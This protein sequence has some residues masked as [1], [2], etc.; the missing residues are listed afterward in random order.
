MKRFWTGVLAAGVALVMGAGVAAADDLAK[1]KDDGVMKIAMS[2]AYPPFNFVNDR[3]EVVGFDA[4]IG[5]EIAKRIGVEGRIVTTAWDGI[6]A[7]LLAKKYDTIVGSMTIT[8]E[9]EKVVDFV[10]PYYHAGRAV[11][12]TET[13][14]VKSLADLKGKT[15]GVTLGET[16]E[17]WA[18]AQDGWS[19]RTY[20]G[21]PE[22]LLELKAGRVQAIVND[23]IP[24]RVAIKEN[25]EKLRQLD[26]PDIEGGAVAIGIAIRKNNP[27][28]HAAMQ[29]ALDEMMADGTYEKIS[30]EWVGADIR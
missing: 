16:H 3:N 10:G 19:V 8:P 27:D 24:V 26:T 6:L 17:K 4:A 11:F 23:N 1:I 15:V 22:L 29:T 12:V 28:L 30:M 2:G 21:L 25:G 5:R 13:S 18:R 14:D 20:K 9:R 7:G